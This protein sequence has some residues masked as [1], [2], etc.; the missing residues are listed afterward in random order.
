MP[1][2]YEKEFDVSSVG[3]IRKAI[4]GLDD[5]IEVGSEYNA[6]LIFLI[7]THDYPGYDGERCVCK[8]TLEIIG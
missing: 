3:D 7:R 2:T 8:P 4:E 1:E 5:D 6:E